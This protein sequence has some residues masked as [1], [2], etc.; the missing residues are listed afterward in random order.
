MTLTVNGGT[1][2]S[3]EGVPVRKLPRS[4]RWHPTVR[5]PALLTADPC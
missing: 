2:Q 4:D 1:M 3:E 5:Q